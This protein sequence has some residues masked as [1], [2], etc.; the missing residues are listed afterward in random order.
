LQELKLKYNNESIKKKKRVRIEN[1]II[2]NYKR[3]KII[4]CKKLKDE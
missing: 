4:E 2:K 1:F 3:N